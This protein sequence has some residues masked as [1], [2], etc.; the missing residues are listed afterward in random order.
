MSKYPPAAYRLLQQVQTLRGGDVT[1]TPIGEPDGFGITRT[2]K[3]DEGTAD[4]LEPVLNVLE[5]PR[6]EQ[7]CEGQVT[8]VPDIRADFRHGFDLESADAALNGADEQDSEGDGA[9][10]DEP[11]EDVENQEDDQ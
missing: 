11:S 5:D 6:I 8:F 9:D 1:M 10:D 2:V 7:A 4:W 3:F